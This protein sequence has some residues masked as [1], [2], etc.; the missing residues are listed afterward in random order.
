M[1]EEET[2]TFLPLLT[3]DPNWPPKAAPLPVPRPQPRGPA[4]SWNWALLS[5]CPQAARPKPKV[6]AISE[7]CWLPFQDPGR[8]V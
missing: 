1:R 6:L 3:R 7:A 4:C 5:S 2:L 8:Q